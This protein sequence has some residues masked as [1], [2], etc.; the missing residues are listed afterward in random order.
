MIGS[1]TPSNQSKA[2]FPKSMASSPSDATLSGAR[3]SPSLSIVPV[4]YVLLG[5]ILLVAISLLNFPYELI[6]FSG[7][8]IKVVVRQLRSI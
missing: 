8:H 7:D 5:L 6:L 2:P 1:G 3:R 4:A